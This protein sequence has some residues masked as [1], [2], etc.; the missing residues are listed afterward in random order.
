[1]QIEHFEDKPKLLASLAAREARM[2]QLH[3]P[4]IAPLTVFVEKLRCEK[5]AGYEIPNFDPWDGG[6]AAEVLFLFEAPGPQAKGSGFISRNNPDPSA[7]NFF[8]FNRQIGI[9][10]KRT[11]SW[12]IVPWYIGIDG[13]SRIRPATSEDIETGVLSLNSLLD[14]LPKL[15]GI[16]LFGKKAQR[17]SSH[18]KKLRPHVRQFEAPH[19]S[20]QAINSNPANK[21]KILNMLKEIAIFLD[22]PQ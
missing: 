8:E 19:P 21:I 17:G 11:I 13:G 15:R 7:N 4:H 5:G 10:R 18:I 9:C 20:L 22:A 6:T 1:M 3:E 14:L 2:K 16:A 12:N